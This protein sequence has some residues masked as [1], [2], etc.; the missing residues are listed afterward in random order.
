MRAKSVGEKTEVT[1]TCPDDN[2][3]KA[4]LEINLSEIECVR[5]VGHDTKIKLTDTIGIIM[6]YPKIGMKMDN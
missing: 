3:T 5:E 2:E 4:S 6:D 1:I